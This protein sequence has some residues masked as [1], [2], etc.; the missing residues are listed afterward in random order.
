M[1]ILSTQVD[2]VLLKHFKFELAIEIFQTFQRSL[3]VEN[4]NRVIGTS[5]FCWFGTR[6]LSLGRDVHFDL[7][8]T[9][10]LFINDDIKNV[11]IYIRQMSNVKLCLQVFS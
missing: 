5:I 9:M 7:F 4:L 1:D 3:V 6:I 8:T 2:L 10:F 11:S